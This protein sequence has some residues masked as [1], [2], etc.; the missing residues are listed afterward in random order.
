MRVQGWRRVQTQYPTNTQFR[1]PE[2]EDDFYAPP[3]P[4]GA[5]GIEW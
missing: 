1:G 3:H 5:R 4:L 2:D